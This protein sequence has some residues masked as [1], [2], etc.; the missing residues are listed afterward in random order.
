MDVA[1][2]ANS[3]A[4]LIGSSKFDKLNR[5]PSVRDNLTDLR[6]ALTDADIWGLPPEHIIE[7]ADETDPQA[8]IE[9]LRTAA[10]ATAS[11]GLL[12]YYYAG[13]GLIHAGDLMLALPG[14]DPRRP[15]EK[16]VSYAKLREATEESGTQRM[17]IIIDCCLAGRG[18]REVVS[19]ADA[20]SRLKHHDTE[21]LCLWAAVGANKAATAP[22]G[23][24]NTAFTGALLEI[25]TAGSALSTPVLTLQ[26]IADEVERR[27]TNGGYQ[28]PELRLSNSGGGIPL[29]RNIRINRRHKTG[30]VLDANNSVT[31]PELR[32]VRMLVLRHD[33]T[34][35][36][37]VRLN[38]PGEELDA[39]MRQWRPKITQPPRL[40]DGGP[41]ARDGFIALVR[42]KAGA[43]KPIRYTEIR[44]NL[45]SLQLSDA[46][47]EVRERVAEMRI[48]RGYLGWG[49]G[50]LEQLINKGELSVADVSAV[51]ATFAR[52]AG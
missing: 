22:V 11:D 3:R 31:D 26:A 44:D 46:Q 14:T 2:P 5:L 37:G 27:L 19:A 45:G 35:A 1:N 13:H 23:H 15:D 33:E 32:G 40:Y 20:A 51:R 17:V 49:P 7:F 16:T 18:G 10:S 30:C 9:A 12:L 38:R 34:G 29:A 25:L 28:R 52:S 6:R 39:S 36:I 41:L 50:G 24:R 48:F 42:I 47:P 43:K 21:D 4:V 8:I